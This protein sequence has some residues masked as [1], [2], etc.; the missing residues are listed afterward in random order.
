MLQ[1]IV[2]AKN[3]S[4][5]YPGIADAVSGILF[6]GT[7]HQGSLFAQYATVLARAANA[8]IIGSQVSRLTG[9]IRTELLA[10]LKRQEP[11][12]LKVAED[13]RPYTTQIRIFSFIEGRPIRGM[14]ERV[15]CVAC[16]GN[17]LLTM[18]PDCR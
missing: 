13:F 18:A 14:N 1:A 17:R 4:K 7:P 15:S 8:V 3:E 5:M 16:T 6:L 11:E 9:P 2:I 12:L 10:S